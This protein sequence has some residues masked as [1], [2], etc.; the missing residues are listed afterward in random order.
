VGEGRVSVSYLTATHAR[1]ELKGVIYDLRALALRLEIE[2]LSDLAQMASSDGDR[3][4]E[5][6]KTWER[7]IA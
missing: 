7:E 2:G 3:V 6:L 5:A 1:V 4:S